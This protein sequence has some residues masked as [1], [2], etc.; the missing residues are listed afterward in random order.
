MTPF[1]SQNTSL[2]VITGCTR[3]SPIPHLHSETSILQVRA[4]TE[5]LASQYLAAALQPEHPSFD[6]VTADPPPRLVKK[7]LASLHRTTV[8]N[9]SGP[10]LKQTIQNLH[11][12]HVQKEIPNAPLNKLLHLRNPPKIHPE[13][14]SLPR[15]TRTLLSQLRSGYCAKLNDYKYRISSAPSPLFRHCHASPET[16]PHIFS[17]PRLPSPLPLMSL[18]NK[19]SRSAAFVATFLDAP[20]E[21]TDRPPPL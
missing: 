16:V 17:C 10:T 3:T 13:E 2:R 11:T 7:T 20:P 1:A 8:N 21:P 5:L 18:W 4:H 6:L 14:K 19:P 12:H 9:S 15:P